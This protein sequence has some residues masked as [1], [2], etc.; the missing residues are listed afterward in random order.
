[1]KRAPKCLLAQ[2]GS[3]LLEQ[4]QSKE[5]ANSS[6]SAASHAQLV[7]PLRPNARCTRA[8]A[9]QATVLDLACCGHQRPLAPPGGSDRRPHTQWC[10]SRRGSER[11]RW[12]SDPQRRAA[13]C[14]SSVS[15]SAAFG[16]SSLG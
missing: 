9:P 4:F 14:A 11:S 1:M 3:S 8:L 5:L 13:L 15:C 10:A 6:A 16:V 2:Q 12:V 7:S